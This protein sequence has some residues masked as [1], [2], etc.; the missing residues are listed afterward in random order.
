MR[1]TARLKPCPS[2][3]SS[4]TT[5]DR[6]FSLSVIEQRAHDP[7]DHSTFGPL[8]RGGRHVMHQLVRELRDREGLQPYP[9]WTSQG[10]EKDSISAKNHVLDTRN[11]G[12]LK[13]NAGLK[14]SYVPRMD[15]QCLSG[16][17]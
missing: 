8:S 5:R 12:D 4:Q 2:S 10:G 3:G 14:R 1:F 16:R 17:Q 13:R 9:A 7:T 6:G 15:T 11:P